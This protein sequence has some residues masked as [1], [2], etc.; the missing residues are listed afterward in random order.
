M[1]LTPATYKLGDKFWKK[2]EFGFRH[3]EFEVLMGHQVDIA[4]GT[5]AH[6]GS[7]G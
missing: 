2:D 1:C 6:E 4:P 3:G 7:V 5:G